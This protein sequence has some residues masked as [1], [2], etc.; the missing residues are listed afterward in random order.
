MSQI[1]V[2]YE[3]YSFVKCQTPSYIWVSSKGDQ[4]MFARLIA[5]LQLRRSTAFLLERDDDHLLDDI[6][7]TRADLQA[8]HRGASLADARASTLRFHSTPTPRGLPVG[9]SA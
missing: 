8:M 7:L 6:G 4:I 2:T 1:Y 9:A 5:L 3:S